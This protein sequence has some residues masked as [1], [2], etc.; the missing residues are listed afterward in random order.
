MAVKSSEPL[1]PRNLPKGSRQQV[2]AGMQRA[3]IPLA[4]RQGGQPSL[5]RSSSTQAPPPPVSASDGFN[6]VRLLAEHG[7]GEFPFLTQARQPA[8]APAQ[9]AAAGPTSVMDALQ[10]SANSK[11][12]TAVM[13]RLRSRR[14]V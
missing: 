6:P 9:E 2:R 7:P 13:M 4:P 11:F 12:A 3:G 14:G 8:T 5:G 1:V 10:H